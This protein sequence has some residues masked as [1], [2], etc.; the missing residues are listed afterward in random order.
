MQNTGKKEALANA[1]SHRPGNLALKLILG[2]LLAGTVLEV[3][4]FFGLSVRW[5]L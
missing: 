2:V 3:M 5:G 4:T 1:A